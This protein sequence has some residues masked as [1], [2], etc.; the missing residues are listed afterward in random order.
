MSAFRPLRSIRVRRP[1]RRL[2]LAA[3]LAV[4]AAAAC[5]DEGPPPPRPTAINLF[6]AQASLDAVG[7]TRNFV[8]NVRDQNGVAMTD[9]E[10]TWSSSDPSVVSIDINGR[11][12]AVGNGSAVIRAT[13]GDAV[14]QAPV[15]VNQAATALLKITGD[16]QEGAAGTALSSPIRVQVVDRLSSPVQGAPI[17]FE[18]IGGGGSVTPGLTATDAG[19]AAEATW[20]LGPSAG[21]EQGVRAAIEGSAVPGVAFTALGFAGPPAELLEVGGADQTGLAGIALAEPLRVKIVDAFGNPFPGEVTFTVLSGGGSISPEMASTG[22][23]GVASAT[24]TLG[25]SLGE[26]TARAELG[27]LRWDFRAT[28]ANAAGPPV[29]LEAIEGDGASGPAGFPLDQPLV[30]VARDANGIG[31]QGVEITFTPSAGSVD[32]TTAMTDVSGRAATSWTLGRTEGP[33]QVVATSGTLAAATFDVD[34]VDPGPTCF[35]DPPDNGQFNITLCFVTEVGGTVETAFLDAQER[36][37]TLITDD[38]SDIPSNPDDNVHIQCGGPGAPPM[39][40][41]LLDDVVIFATIEEIDGDF[42]VL[43][44]AGPC[45]IRN[46]N[47]LTSVGRMRFDIADLDRLAQSGRLE[48]VILHEMGHVIGIGTLWS[49]LGLLQNPVQDT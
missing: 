44:S 20:T 49:T 35:L 22:F 27:D 18:V 4:V 6:P 2:P 30:A 32:P 48:D 40:G 42:G 31:V 41:P 37:E 34:A 36:W 12:E 1:S 7:E 19:G 13:S 26:Q 29:S 23:A 10:I 33:Q 46:S 25:A 15:E 43:G 28:A 9:Q 45:F 11:A 24:W 38:L 8:A 14:G 21:Q 5:G 3:L 47:S 39:T 16:Q 17:R